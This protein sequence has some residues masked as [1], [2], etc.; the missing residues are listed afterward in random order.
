MINKLTLTFPALFLCLSILISCKPKPQHKGQWR[1]PA[2]DGVYQEVNLV[3]TWPDDGPEKLWQLDSLGRGYAAPV[4]IDG[5]IYLNTEKN[6][7][8]FLTALDTQGKK[9]WSIPNGREFVGEGYSA[10][11]PGARSTPT[12][13]G[14]LAYTIS[15]MGRLL[16]ANIQTGKELWSINLVD[17][18]GA[19]VPMFGFSESLLVDEEKLFCFP[20]GAEHNL[21]ALDRFSGEMIWTSKAKKDTFSYCSPILKVIEG[22]KVLI[23]HS[24]HAMYAAD[25]ETGDILGSYKLLGFEWDGDHCNSPLYHDGAIYFIGADPKGEG[26]LKIR[27]TD[28]KPGMEKVWN[29][30]RIKNNFN[31]Y[32][33]KDDLLFTPVKG[34]WIKALDIHTGLVK[35]SIKAASGS[36]I[37]ADNKFY[38]YG[39]N[40][41]VNLISYQ[42]QVFQNHG[43]FKMKEGTGHHFSHPVIHKGVLYIRHG[44][45]LMAWKI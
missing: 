14:E 8:S 23:G 37:Y 20:G 6:G 15:G 26:A 2:R 13:V 1:G 45:T 12:V 32:I 10:T 16:C 22:R 33:L 30:K 43:S 11:Y 31:G 28:S 3:D 29:N 44:D 36:L 39:M 9:L 4:V 42:N 41:E 5:T 34:N 25:C 24:R 38:C 7:K 17:D 19:I 18:L 40:G 35:D 27:L 21:V